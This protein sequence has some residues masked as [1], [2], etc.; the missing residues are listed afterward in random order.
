MQ[1][2][3]LIIPAIVATQAGICHDTTQ[4]KNLLQSLNK[5]KI[6]ELTCS[7]EGGKVKNEWRKMYEKFYTK[8]IVNL[9]QS[10]LAEP[11]NELFP[12]IGRDPRFYA[13]GAPE[14]VKDIH[15]GTPKIQGDKATVFVSFMALDGPDWNKYTTEYYLLRTSDGWRVADQ[16]F[17]KIDFKEITEKRHPELLVLL[18]GH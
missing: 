1:T 6:N 12:L 14:K 16:W 8:E 10:R 11:Q 3:L 4:I 15:V 17:G 7:D 2:A 18:Q 9:V 5:P 13:A